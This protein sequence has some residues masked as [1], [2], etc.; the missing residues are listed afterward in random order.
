[1]KSWHRSNRNSYLKIAKRSLRTSHGK[2]LAL[3]VIA[4]LIYFPTWILVVGRITFIS[5]HS[6]LIL[7]LGSL[8]FGMTNLWQQRTEIASIKVLDDDRLVGYLLILG[9]FV[10]LISQSSSSSIQAASA[11][12]VLAGILMSSFG[13]TVLKYYPLSCIVLLLS[14]YPDWAFLS[15][16]IFHFLTGPSFLENVMAQWG[17]FALNLIGQSSAVSGQYITLP[18][19]SVLVA[20]GC[21]GF[22][23]AFSVAVSSILLGL[24]MNQSSIRIIAA[25]FVGIALALILNVPRIV[26][27]SLAAVYWGQESFEFWHGAWGGA[28]FLRHLVYNLLLYSYGAL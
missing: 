3:G 6:T 24:F 20:S 18:T 1:M 21:S 5:G 26:L 8:Y 9:G 11:M 14:L 2:M 16:L 10:S 28:D 25:A 22:D 19:G 13:M 4:G 12:L 17:S 15:N 7:N 27:L 23:M